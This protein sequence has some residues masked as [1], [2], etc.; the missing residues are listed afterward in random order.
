MEFY[1]NDKVIVNPLRIRSDILS[2]LSYC[3]VLYF[4]GKSRYSSKIIERQQNS[5]LQNEQAKIE[6]MHL[7]KKQAILMKEALLKGELD[8][9]GPILDFGWQNKKKMASG[10]SSDYIDKIY[11]DVMKAGSTGGKVS[12]AGGGGFMF[13][14][15]PNN[16]KYKVIDV[17]KKHGGETHNFNFSTKG[18][19]SWTI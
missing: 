9:I 16:T 10:I 6:A 2:E 17:L 18:L 13:F 8:K 12:G 4:T 15:C 1:D 14:Y 3:T 7:I 5:V 19:V 11:N